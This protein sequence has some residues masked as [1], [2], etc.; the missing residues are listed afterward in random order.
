MRFIA[1]EEH[2]MPRDIAAAAGIDPSSFM[3]LD[4]ALDDVTALRLPAMDEAGIAMQVLSVPN[5]DIQRLGAA[6]ASGLSRELNDRLHAI[7]AERP[8]RFRA[9]ASL[10]MC[11][12][13][14]AAEEFV[15]AV[16]DLGCVGALVSGQT[17]GVFLD[18]PTMAPVL[19]VAETLQVPIYLHPAP[20]PSA[21]FDAYFAG[22]AAPV[23]GVLS[24]AGWGWHVETGMHVLRMVTTGTFDRHP[25]LQVIVGH[26]GENLPFSLARA[27]ERLSSVTGLSRSVAEIIGDHLWVTTCGYTT[28]APLLCAEMA[29][30][31][32]RMMFSVDYPFS[33]CSQATRFIAGSPLSPAAREK[34]A[35]GNAEWLLGV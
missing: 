24:T 29:I 33:D 1:L 34:I 20:P 13:N 2:V 28:V 27:D 32:D 16:D 23:A 14:S 17:N 26:M 19:A 22:L 11:D 9:F 15:R 35:H 8:D 12:P 4:V 6:R 7:V 25:G 30:G 5:A 31:A 10:P 21:V 18:D 3:G